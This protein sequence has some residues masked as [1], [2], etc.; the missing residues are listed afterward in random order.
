MQNRRK[1]FTIGLIIA[2][3]GVILL[4]ADKIVSA[5]SNTSFTQSFSIITVASLIILAIAVVWLFFF[6][7]K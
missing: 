2:A 6:S 7:L 4:G 1:N 5:S 3:I